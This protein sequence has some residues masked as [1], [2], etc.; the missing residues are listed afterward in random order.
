MVRILSDE[1]ELPFKNRGEALRSLYQHIKEDIEWFG[2]PSAETTELGRLVF[3]NYF[4]ARQ[5]RVAPRRTGL[6]FGRKKVA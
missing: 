2:G 4:I 3:R 5:K 6:H 1:P